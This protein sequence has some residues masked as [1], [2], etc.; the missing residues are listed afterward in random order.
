MG[1]NGYDCNSLGGTIQY[2]KIQINARLFWERISNIT[3]KLAYGFHVLFP[4]EEDWL[5][6]VI[7]V[8]LALRILYPRILT[9][10]V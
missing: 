1:I 5:F 10:L 9:R 2:E 8:V 6:M 3:M 4:L 7:G